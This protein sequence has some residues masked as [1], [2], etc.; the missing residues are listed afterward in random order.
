MSH[1]EWHLEVA[2]AIVTAALKEKE[3][4][5]EKYGNEFSP[6]G[7]FSHFLALPIESFVSVFAAAM[8]QVSGGAN[9]LEETNI[10]RGMLRGESGRPLFALVQTGEVK[11]EKKR[12][13]I[14]FYPHFVVF[15]REETLAAE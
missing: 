9:G 4:L 7:R 13:F 10:Q 3:H 8:K 6:G 5:K 1:D 15:H 2:K 14:V 12:V 11:N